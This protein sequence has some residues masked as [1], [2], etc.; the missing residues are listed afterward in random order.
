[1]VRLH[2]SP[3]ATE[4]K[5]A[6]IL[7]SYYRPKPGG[8]CKRLFRAIEALLCAG[9][10]VHYLALIPFPVEHPQCHFHRF[11]WP[12]RAT[13][14]ILFWSVFHMLSPMM[15]LYIGVKYRITHAFSFNVT[16]ALV[17]KPVCRFRGITI[18]VF[19]RGDT[20]ESHKI[21]AKMTWL[22]WLERMIEGIAI[23]GEALY[24]VSEAL[25]QKVV[26]RHSWAVPLWM[27][28]LPNDITFTEVNSVP[29]F[30]TPL[31]L[32]CV[33]TLDRVKNH[34]L[35]LRA[36]K[37]ISSEA[38]HF[39]FYGVGVEEGRLAS[40]VGEVGIGQKVTFAGWIDEHKMWP[41][42]DLLLM[43]SLDE[44]APNA[45]LEAI[46]HGIPVLASD[47]PAHRE[48]VSWN[49][50][51]PINDTEAWAT[52]VDLM[53]SQRNSAFIALR[54]TQRSFAEKFAFDWDMEISNRIL[55]KLPQ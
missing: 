21:K 16:Y 51:L 27:D 6:R 9:H 12:F 23:H 40:V 28:V 14:N 15:L 25:V 54:D 24:G 11:P 13:E 45:V 53:I 38:W 55:R 22:I 5:P 18:A 33:G 32:A 36:L 1:M 3:M 50:L 31:R 30:D 4:I 49:L 37:L 39:S 34:E 10:T 29:S 2:L 20:I 42:I 48:L 35:I 43:P 52:A 26:A 47:I 7:T 8:C 41:E 19:L 44:G 46:A 17:M